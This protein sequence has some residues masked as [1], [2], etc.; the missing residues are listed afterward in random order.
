MKPRGQ[1]EKQSSLLRSAIAAANAF[2]TL[3]RRH[4]TLTTRDG[5]K[6]VTI[7]Q[8]ATIK[9][10]IPIGTSCVNPC[11]M[12]EAAFQRTDAITNLIDWS[13]GVVGRCRAPL[14]CQLSRSLFVGECLP[15]SVHLTSDAQHFDCQI[16]YWRLDFQPCSPSIILQGACALPRNL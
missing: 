6:V 8:D 9:G 16:A 10:D 11:G 5:L 3:V 1:A 13:D 2:A 7:W 12:R 15:A 14:H 4:T